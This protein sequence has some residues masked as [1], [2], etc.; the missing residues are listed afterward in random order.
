MSAPPADDLVLDVRNLETVYATAAG[1][2]AAVRDVSLAIRR[3]EKL[4]IVGESGSGKSALALSILGLVREPGSVR[5]GEVWVNGR[6]TRALSDRRRQAIRGREI[7]LIYQDPLSAL[8]PLRTVGE[9]IAEA[10]RAGQ[11]AL[12][13]AAARRRAVELL[14]EVEV[15]SP[16]RRAGDRP[17]QFSGGMRQ[18]VMIAIAIANEPDLIIA[19]EPTTALDV[20][21][22]AQ[23]FALLERLV[24]DRGAAIALITHN[25]GVVARF[26]DTVHVM[27]AGR[28]VEQAPVATL[29]DHPAHPY[30]AA[31]LDAVPRPDR[32]RG[33]LPAI[34]GEPPDLT[35]LPAGCAFAPRCPIGH[36]REDCRTLA[37]A[38]RPFSASGPEVRVACHHAETALAGARR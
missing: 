3:G 26:C 7:S 9:Q 5:A 10:I 2:V 29:F 32:P 28:L 24:A 17:H 36:D 15:P 25:M 19:D 13:R 4:A 23:V 31:L 21:T 27:Y 20:T 22:Q 35:A 18:R 38:D 30:S 12:G 14:G 8:D 37:P 6:E 16:A 1:E 11:P 34:P 33:R